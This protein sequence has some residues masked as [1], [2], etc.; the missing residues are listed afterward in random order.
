RPRARRRHDQAGRRGAGGGGGPFGSGL[1]PS[2]EE[3]RRPV[4]Q[5]RQRQGHPDPVQLRRR[6]LREEGRPL[7]HQGHDLRGQEGGSP[8]RTRPEGQ[9]RRRRGGRQQEGGQRVVAGPHLRHRRR[10]RGPQEQQ[11][12]TGQAQ[13]DGGQVGRFQ[14]QGPRPQEDGGHQQGGGGA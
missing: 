2:R 10:A 14:H 3:R 12:A 5:R 13:R 7:G 6:D 8:A 4:L 1:R 11:A 9:G